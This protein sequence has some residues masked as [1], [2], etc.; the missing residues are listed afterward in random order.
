MPWNDTQTKRDQ[1]ETDRQTDRQTDRHEDR[2][3]KYT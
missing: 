1:N 3:K 2:Q